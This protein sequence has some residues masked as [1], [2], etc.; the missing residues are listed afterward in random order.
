MA[1][2]APWRAAGEYLFVGTAL[3]AA[4]VL[5]YLLG[6]WIDGKLGSSP[7]GMLIG[8]LLGVAAGFVNLWRIV[9]KLQ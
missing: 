7:W 1:G 8:V 6:S 2:E 5:G 4:L 3:V 9:K